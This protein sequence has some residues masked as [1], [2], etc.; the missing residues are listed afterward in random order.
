MRAD[1]VRCLQTREHRLR[2]AIAVRGDVTVEKIVVIRV[3]RVVADLGVLA[4]L[5][6]VPFHRLERAMQR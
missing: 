3:R 2:V 1:V 4:H 6:R 5:A